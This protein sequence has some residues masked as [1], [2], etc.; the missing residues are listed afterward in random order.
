MRLFDTSIVDLLRPVLGDEQVS[1]VGLGLHDFQMTTATLHVQ[2]FLRVDFSIGGS[3]HA[4]EGGP[5]AAPVWLL[6]SQTP[7]DVVLERPSALRLLFGG[8]DWI[9]LHTDEGPHE[10]QTFLL[11]RSSSDPNLSVF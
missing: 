10:A 7:N 11:S 8:G 6:V 2:N 3:T 5:C 4:W 9:R 1:F